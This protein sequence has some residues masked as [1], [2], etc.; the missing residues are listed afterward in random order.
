MCLSNSVDL[1]VNSFEFFL[2]DSE[3]SSSNA[4]LDLDGILGMSP[5]R[6]DTNPNPFIKTLFDQGM[7]DNAIATFQLNDVQDEDSSMTIG[8]IPDGIIDGETTTLQNL[9]VF[10]HDWWTVGL[11]DVK[12]NNSTIKSSTDIHEAILDTGTDIIT[13]P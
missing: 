5:Y 8:G 10:N 12:Y 1:C 3:F 11:E 6:S 9:V 2:I 13:M 4:A 7:I